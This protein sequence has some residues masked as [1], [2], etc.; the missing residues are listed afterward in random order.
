MPLHKGGETVN[1]S[2]VKVVEKP[3]EEVPD[4]P[5]VSVEKNA[6]SEQAQENVDTVQ[7]G[8]VE[9]TSTMTSAALP[10]DT[11]P[12]A[13]VPEEP[14]KRPKQ[15]LP[16][17]DSITNGESETGDDADDEADAPAEL[18]RSLS[19]KDRLKLFNDQNEDPKFPPPLSPKLKPAGGGQ[20]PPGA[21]QAAEFDT[22]DAAQTHTGNGASDGASDGATTQPT[23]PVSPM[24][25]PTGSQSESELKLPSKKKKKKK[26]PSAEEADSP[27]TPKQ[28]STEQLQAK[29]EPPKVDPTPS[30][31]EP[32]QA[33]RAPKQVEAAPVKAEPS[34]QKAKSSPSLGAHERPSGDPQVAE[35]D[36]ANETEADNEWLEAHF[37][38]TRSVSMGA[39]ATPVRKKS[40]PGSK[41]KKSKGG[42]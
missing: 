24:L 38:L 42:K 39:H 6:P 10:A 30:T 4:K 34:P 8:E 36:D 31:V 40:T 19:V 28:G 11:S 32:P 2:E 26:G 33:V 16:T 17:F 13:S 23:P 20:T 9:D 3:K 27:R 25:L 15:R 7:I 22:S 1:L 18:E 14:A 21:N 41:R 35:D 12:T 29:V 5:L 37:K